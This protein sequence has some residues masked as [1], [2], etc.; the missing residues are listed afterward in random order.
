MA[1]VLVVSNDDATAVEVVKDMDDDRDAWTIAIC[2]VHGGLERDHSYFE[3]VIE[4]G[5][6]PR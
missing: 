4:V 2:P 5:R 3:D 6:D 1:R